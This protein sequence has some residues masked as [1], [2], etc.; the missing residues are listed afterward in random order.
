MPASNPNVNAAKQDSNASQLWAWWGQLQRWWRRMPE[1]RQDRFAL[2]GPIA[3]VILFFVATLTALVYLRVEEVT[4]EREGMRRDVDYAQQ[5]LRLRLLENQEQIMRLARE[6]TE[7]GLTL[8]EFMQRGQS[9]MAQE[10]ELRTLVRFDRRERVHMH[11]LSP[12]SSSSMHWLSG[13]RLVSSDMAT[14]YALAK[15]LQQPIFRVHAPSQSSVG[16]SAPNSEEVLLQLYVPIM[17]GESHYEGMLLAQYSVDG[18]LRYGIPPEVSA[19]YAL[20]L[21]DGIGTVLAGQSIKERHAWFD[22]IPGRDPKDLEYSVLISPVS[23]SFMLR[24]QAWRT[25]PDFVTSGLFWL[26][27]VLSVITSWLLFASWLHTRRRSQAQK[28]LVAETNFRRAM[29]NSMLIGMRALDLQGRMMYVNPAFCQMT[30][31]TETELVGQEAPFSYWPEEERE[32][33]TARLEEELRGQSTP[34]GNQ[35]RFK[36]KDGSRFDARLYVSPLIDARGKQTGWITSMTDITEPHR[37][38][39]QLQASHERFMVVMEAL[40]A[41]I[42]VAPLGST[43]LL[44]ANRLYRQ[45]F[46]NEGVTSTEGHLQ[47]LAQAHL[48]GNVQGQNFDTGADAVD[49]WAGLPSETLVA[50][51]SEHAEIYLSN[52]GKWLEVR[53]RYLNWV[54]GRIVQMV[55]ATDITAR[56]HAEEQAAQQAEQ[57]QTASRLI[58]MGEMASSLAHELNQPLTAITNYCSGMLSRIKS[59]NLNQDDFQNALQKTSHQAQRAGQII[60]RIRNFVGRSKPN[61]SWAQV[62][63]MVSEAAELAEIELRKLDVKLKQEIAPRLPALPV[64]PILIEQV[65]IN[66]IKNGAESVRLAQRNGADRWVRLQVSAERVA[67][68]S[69]VMFRVTDPGLGLAPEVMERMYEAFYTTKTEGMGMGLNLCRSIVESH[70]G[71]IEAENLYNGPSVVGCVFRFWIPLQVA[72][73]VE[74]E[75]SPEVAA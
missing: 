36:R 21:T 42:S 63:T 1:S 40:D 22:L 62:A 57:A 29:E 7:Q 39:E 61:R 14:T 49:G 23:G 69:V 50:A 66:L 13:Q 52:L 70:Q 54:D 41:S 10:S 20:A 9:I 55:I 30:G 37:I 33:L 19:K 44:F 48:S 12:Y 68:Q 5:R 35:V 6:L 74:P 64:D 65:L 71:R 72:R 31:W 17:S 16:T 15:D 67:G 18:L 28:A 73:D 32:F 25:A 56:R 27:V 53:A 51:Q 45:W 3:A 58:T 38:R 8:A 59:D 4:R 47:L 60:Q 43:E 2:L 46:V 11:A 26:V 34:G 75:N 24:A